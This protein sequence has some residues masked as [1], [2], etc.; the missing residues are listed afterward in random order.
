MKGGGVLNNACMKQEIN[1]DT[2]R[3]FKASVELTAQI[4]VDLHDINICMGILYLQEA[5][6]IH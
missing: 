1:T 4:Q 5:G 2:G 3:F 6:R